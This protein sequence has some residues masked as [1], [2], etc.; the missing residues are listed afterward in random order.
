[1]YFGSDSDRAAVA[2]EAAPDPA[3]ARQAVLG[4]AVGHLLHVVGLVLVAAGLHDVVAHPNAPLSV[5]IA[6]TM[7][8]GCATFLVAQAV[9]LAQVGLAFGS[10]LA[11]AAAAALAVA[12]IGH[13]V[14]ALAEL[15]A[16]VVILVCTV[17]TRG[18]RRERPSPSIA[19]SPS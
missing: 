16:L 10:E 15:G 5:R 6:M 4:Y 18:A 14:N 9:F 3:R 11:V 12:V 13:S 1:V 19:G 2:L 7:A 8:A 17:A